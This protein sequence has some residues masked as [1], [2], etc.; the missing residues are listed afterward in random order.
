MVAGLGE[1]RFENGHCAI[2]ARH[3]RSGPRWI[4]ECRFAPDQA[5]EGIAPGAIEFG[6]LP[7][8]PLLDPGPA[9]GIDWQQMPPA[10]LGGELAA[11]RVRFPEKEARVLD[12]RHQAVGVDGKEFWGCACSGSSCHNFYYA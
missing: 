12:H 7:V 3:V 2:P 4:L 11:D 6:G 10:G 5:H 8:H 9:D 1:P